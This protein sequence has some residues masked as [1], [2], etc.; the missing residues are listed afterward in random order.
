[1][2]ARHLLSILVLGL[3]LPSLH[4]ADGPRWGVPEEDD[5]VVLTDA[6]FDD[7]LSNH[8]WVFI[9]YYAPWC[10]HCK[11]MAPSYSE[12]AIENKFKENGIPIAKLEATVNKKV[13]EKMKPQGFPTLRLYNRGFEID[14]KGG[15]D[16][17]D[18]Q[19]F[20][21]LKMAV[22]PELIDT[23]DEFDE[24][25]GARL[26]AI[27]YLDTKD[28]SAVN[29]FR[30]FILQ[31]DNIPFAYTHNPQ[32]QKL[33]G[34]K[35]SATLYVIRNF[36]DGDKVVDKDRPFTDNELSTEFKKVRF[37]H[38]M[39]FND[40]VMHRLDEEKKNTLYLYTADRR[41]PSM[42]LFN[43]IAPK[44]S[45]DFFFVVADATDEKVKRMAEYF[46]VG[47]KNENVRLMGYKG[48]KNQKFKANEI[49]EAAITQLLDDHKAGKARQYLKTDSIPPA[50]NNPVK[51]VVGA[52]FGE[53]IIK[54]NKHVLLEI[55]A[56]WCG[57]CKNLEP[58]FNELAV[59]LS[60]YDDILI[61]KMDGTTNEYP[62]VDA[63]GYPTIFF[64]PKGKKD[65]PIKYEGEKTLPKFIYFLN[66]HIGRV[67]KTT[68]LASNEL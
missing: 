46:G 40:D 60:A 51:D 64:F 4:S 61:A 35:G 54:S 53:L 63:Q 26:A 39:E 37:G 45:K 7:F 2:N 38:V 68:T 24:L 33:M 36:D 6:N 31:F 8:E 22:K 49:S 44:Y 59:Q 13:A 41:G 62:K 17:K 48:G 23:E 5:V 52:S 29:A 14:Y 20:I 66:R 57:H 65:K 12:L 15:R 19:A 11:S 10:G 58:I 27:Y 43:K 56:P 25:R 16:K 28:A 1:M 55:H 34:G 67:H 42:E 50:N 3:I 30:R 32:L 18:I 47:G 9:E 21:D